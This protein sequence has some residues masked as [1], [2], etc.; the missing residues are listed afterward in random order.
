MTNFF[1][2]VNIERIVWPATSPDMNPI[3][4]LWDILKRK[5]QKYNVQTIAAVRNAVQGVE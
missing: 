3:E 4:N 2:E 1:N 5:V